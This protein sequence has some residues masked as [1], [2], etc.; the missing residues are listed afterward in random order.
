MMQ[1]K[2]RAVKL[3]RDLILQAQGLSLPILRGHKGPLAP[4]SILEPLLP[5]YMGGK[6]E[7]F[8]TDT[9]GKKFVVFSAK[10]KFTQSPALAPVSPHNAPAS[11]PESS[12]ALEARAASPVITHRLVD[13]Q[14]TVSVDISREKSNAVDMDSCSKQYTP[15]SLAGAL[16]LDSCRI[17]ASHL[18]QQDERKPNLW[19]SSRFDE[20]KT[21]A[22]TSSNR[23][24]PSL[25]D[26]CMKGLDDADLVKQQR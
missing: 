20:K 15:S 6:G 19:E 10:N 25:A 26:S 2:T 18:A 7:G 13:R 4:S 21:A 11:P 5:T 24:S 17:L 23:T 22:I 8:W 12:F 3:V 14:C 9:S 1:A 16:L